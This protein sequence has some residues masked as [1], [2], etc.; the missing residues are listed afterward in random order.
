M[1]LPWKLRVVGKPGSWKPWTFA[2]KFLAYRVGRSGPL[3]A[4]GG[5]WGVS[6]YG[7]KQ[8]TPMIEAIEWLSVGG[9]VEDAWSL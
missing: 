4:D 3:G 7:N 9:G 8:G 5:H 1:G 6:L 2:T